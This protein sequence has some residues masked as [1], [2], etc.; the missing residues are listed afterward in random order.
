MLNYYIR[1]PQRVV[2]LSATFFFSNIK[3][4]FSSSSFPSF[5]ML[6][7]QVLDDIE[8]VLLATDLTVQRNVVRSNNQGGFRADYRWPYKRY[9]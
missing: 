4:F 9:P 3:K 7:R 8:T 5:S 2:T 6:C 1:I